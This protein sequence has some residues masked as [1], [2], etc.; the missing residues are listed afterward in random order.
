MGNENISVAD[1]EKC[2][3]KPIELDAFNQYATLNNNNFNQ[4]LL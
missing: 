2:Y 4:L 3:T 1:N